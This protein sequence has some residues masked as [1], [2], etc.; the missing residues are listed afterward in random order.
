ME[1]LRHRGEPLRGVLNGTVASRLGVVVPIALQSSGH[2]VF[3]R[4]YRVALDLIVDESRRNVAI[5]Q[6]HGEK[7]S[8]FGGGLVYFALGWMSAS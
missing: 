4:K 3:M 7:L 6:A 1:L 2:G 8:L 5:V